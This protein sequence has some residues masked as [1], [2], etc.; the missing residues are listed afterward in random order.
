MLQEV[1]G[2]HSCHVQLAAD[3]LGIDIVASK[4]SRERRRT[5]VEG[6]G[7]SQ[8]V[9]DFVGQREAEEIHADIAVYVL[10]RQHRNRV[11]RRACTRA[12]TVLE[13]PQSRQRQHHHQHRTDRQ[14]QIGL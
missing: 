9:G 8:N 3:F 11:L 14:Q 7:V 5:N 12:L 13:P 10:Q 4:L 2:Q 1:S 6:S